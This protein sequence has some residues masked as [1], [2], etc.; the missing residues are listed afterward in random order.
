MGVNTFFTWSEESGTPA[1]DRDDITQTFGVSADLLADSGRI[2]TGYLDSNG[3]VAQGENGVA[4]AVYSIQDKVI[5]NLG[6]SGRNTTLDAYYSSLIAEVGVD[7]QNARTNEKYNAAL[8]DQYIGR[9]E[10][11]TGVNLDEES[12]ELL[13]YQYLWQAAAKL[14]SICDEMMQSL[15]SIK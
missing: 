15:L 9:K 13:K 7:V 11:I 10:S 3:K 1:S 14:I 6:G 8:L 5:T 2:S 4:L 12:T